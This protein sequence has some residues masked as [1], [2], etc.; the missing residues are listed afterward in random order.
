MSIS[1][2]L[3]EGVASEVAR[4]D[5]AAEAAERH[6]CLLLVDIRGFSALIQSRPSHE[7]IGDLMVFRRF[8]H[9]AV[10]RHNGIFD[11]YLGNGVLAVFLC[12][13]PE[14][15]AAQAFEAACDPAPIGYLEEPRG[16]TIR[17]SRHYDTHCGF[18]LAGVFYDGERAEF[19]ALGPAMNALPRMERRSKEANIGVVM[20]KRFLCLLPPSIRTLIDTRP[21][22]RRPGDE[23]LPDIL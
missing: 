11:K 1:R 6:A 3:P 2:F 5:E 17:C 18:A 23:Q 12:G 4:G 9:E 7:V 15:L 19:T 13:T 10:S 16:R 22:E 14:R 20:S 8:V 21:V